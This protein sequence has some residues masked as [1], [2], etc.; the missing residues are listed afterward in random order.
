MIPLLLVLASAAGPSASASA[1]PGKSGPVRVDAD[2]VHYAFQKRE[3]I[4]TGAP[5]V[6]R[7]DDATLNCRRLVATNDERG[8]IAHAVC[9]GD[10]KFTRGERIVTCEKAT[11]DEAEA[12]LL[13]EGN[14]VLKD[15]PSEARGKRLVYDLRADEAKME[16]PIVTIPG[17]QVD[18]HRKGIGTKRKPVPSVAPP[19]GRPEVEGGGAK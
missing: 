18:A 10:V 16:S 14:P 8:Q 19:T 11:Y 9:S 17:G 3:V 13:C 6:L 2:E 5:V 4:F 15:G 12:R 1:A 7:R